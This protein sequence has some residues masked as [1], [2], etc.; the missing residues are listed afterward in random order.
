MVET[1]HKGCQLLKQ[2]SNSQNDPQKSDNATEKVDKAYNTEAAPTETPLFVV[3]EAALME[4]TTT[5][6][7]GPIF[8]DISQI[9]IP[10]SSD[11]DERKETNVIPVESENED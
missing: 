7:N 11:N 4:Y 6:D 1:C 10:S 5:E 9:V 2:L 8:Y 3:I